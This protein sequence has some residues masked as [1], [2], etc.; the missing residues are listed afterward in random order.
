MNQAEVTKLM[1]QLKIAL[2]PRHRN[3]KTPLGPEGRLDKLRQTVTALIKY[4]RIELF[5]NRADEAR[6]YT[7][8]LVSDALRYGDTHKPMMEMADYWL[9]E[10]Q[11]V[12]KLF[13]VLCPRFENENGS[14]TKMFNAPRVYPADPKRAYFK[15]VVLELKGNPYPTITPDSS[16]RNKNLIHNVLLDAA[17][18]DFYAE[19]ERQQQLLEQEQTLNSVE[20]SK[21]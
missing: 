2:K 20:E 12:H 15:R 3:L 19:K 5:Y 8:R 14:V 11:L 4:E 16:Y 18:K 10:K 17:M 21:K 7:E 1:S 6:G 9:L 13:K